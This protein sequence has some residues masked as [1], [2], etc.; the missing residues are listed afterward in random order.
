MPK[1]TENRIN[2]LIGKLNT[3]EE[4]AR[5]IAKAGDRKLLIHKREV[6]A[7]VD[8]VWS[9]VKEWIPGTIVVADAAWR[10]HTF[11]HDS[12]GSQTVVNAGDE[13][14]VWHI[15]P[16]ARK[17]W[18]IHVNAYGKGMTYAPELSAHVDRLTSAWQRKQL[19]DLT[20]RAAWDNARKHS[21]GYDMQGIRLCKFRRIE[22]HE[23]FGPD[24]VDQQSEQA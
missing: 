1:E 14:V 3:V 9:T 12:S 17:L 5:V 2:R 18:L 22:A 19:D 24:N 7:E 21:V 20:L 6:Q 13:L 10:L 8:R 16:R 23:S 11:D 15:Q 4:L